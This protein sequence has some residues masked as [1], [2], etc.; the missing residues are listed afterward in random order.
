MHAG[1]IRQ[2]SPTGSHSS[3]RC[4]DDQVHD[5]RCNPVGNSRFSQAPAP[6]ADR[7]RTASPTSTR[8]L[9]VPTPIRLTRS[10]VVLD[11][12]LESEAQRAKANYDGTQG[13]D[14][15]RVRARGRGSLSLAMDD[16]RTG[17]AGRH[18]LPSLRRRRCRRIDRAQDLTGRSERRDRLHGHVAGGAPRITAYDADG[19]TASGPPLTCVVDGNQVLALGD[20]DLARDDDGI[21]FGLYMLC[22]SS[23]NSGESPKMSDS[24]GKIVVWWHAGPKGQEDP[25][26][27]WTTSPTIWSTPPSGPRRCN[28]CWPTKRISSCP[29]TPS[30]S[31][32]YEID[33]ST[34]RKW[35][36]IS[37]KASGSDRPDDGSQGRAGSMWVSSCTTTR[38]TSVW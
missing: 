33:S 8:P 17:P 3:T 26:A 32:G 14:H 23:T 6:A 25:A 37:A 36:H 28:A 30:S 16:G 13:R 24:S 20:I 22:H 34:S 19:S 31:I 12:G 15:G 2:V 38:P 27:I 4:R 21:R 11:D 9:W 29:T 18:R 35:P 1:D 5:L 7:D 10:Q